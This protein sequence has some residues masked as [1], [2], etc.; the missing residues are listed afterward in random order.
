MQVQKY[1]VNKNALLNVHKI[2]C[3][4]M[5][6]AAPSTPAFLSGFAPVYV[7]PHK[8]DVRYKHYRGRPQDTSDEKACS[9]VILAPPGLFCR[10]FT[11]HFRCLLFSFS[12]WCVDVPAMRTAH[13]NIY[14]QK[15]F[16]FI[17]RLHDNVFILLRVLIYIHMNVYVASTQI[18]EQT[19]SDTNRHTNTHINSQIHTYVNAFVS[20]HT[21]TTKNTQ[22]TTQMKKTQTITNRQKHKHAQ[23]YMYIH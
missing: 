5:S 7:G 16:L 20:I 15:H 21:K 8:E 14:T 18:H 22:T 3:F 12:T 9:S 19:H 11:L 10:P 2:A 1:S 23:I 13:V 17:S 4:S 6:V